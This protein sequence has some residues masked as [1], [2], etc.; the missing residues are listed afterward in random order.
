MG[1]KHASPRRGRFWRAYL[2]Y[3]LVLL[4]ISLGVLAYLWHFLADYQQRVDLEAENAE[5]LRLEEE[6]ATAELRAPQKALEEFLASADADY[7]T[8]RWFLLHPED[9]EPWSAAE[10]VIQ[11]LMD[12][13]DF[14]AY[15]DLA[16]TPEAPVYLLKNDDLDFARIR[17]TGSGM[18]WS[19]SETELLLEGGGSARVETVASAAVFWGETEMPPEGEPYSHFPLG[20][21]D[22]L[23]EPVLYKTVSV[24]GTLAQPELRVEPPPG[25]ELAEAETE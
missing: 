15:K 18:Q 1:G 5:R 17:L 20:K 6:Q 16:Y 8:S 14:G 13:P 12:R 19:V 3:V 10:A 22:R 24:S 2:I 25:R 11:G 23:E 9:P 4:L 21:D 7:W